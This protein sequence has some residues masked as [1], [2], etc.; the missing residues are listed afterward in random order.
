MNDSKISV[1]YSKALFELAI[2]EG[3]L[4]V[5]EADMRLI[6]ELS[7][8]PD[9]K[10]LIESPV[11]PVSKKISIFNASF[12][13][14]LCDLSLKLAG[15]VISNGREQFLPAIARNLLES[16]RQYHGITEVTLTTAIA[17]NE[18]VKKSIADM[19]S[20]K[21]MT[22][23]KL[24]EIVDEN[25]IGGFILRVDDNLIDASVK[26]RLRK[27]RKSLTEK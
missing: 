12:G 16:S 18:G 13:D 1:R 5:V 19:V 10:V 14:S 25:I 7:L 22:E 9:F 20:A 24:K 6:L 27:I 15:Q 3:I 23:V 26:T 2:E 17:A 11:I 21:F 4:N 8:N